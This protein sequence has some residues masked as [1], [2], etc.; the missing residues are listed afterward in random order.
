MAR[1]YADYDNMFRFYTAGTGTS[2]GWPN[3]GGRTLLLRSLLNNA[4]FKERFI[5]RCADLLNSLFR[6]EKVEQTIQ[7][8]ASV[9]RPEI[10][11]HLHRWS[12]SELT[13]RGFGVPH[14]AEY[15]AFTQAT[16][17]T[18]ITVLSA[19]GRNRPAKLRQDCTN[20]FQL[21]GGLGTL[22]VQVQPEGSGRVLLNS[23]T[24]DLFPWQGI[25]FADITNTVRPIPS[26][27][28]RFVEW[29][30]PSGNTNSQ[31][32]SFKVQRDRTNTFTARME[33]APTNPSSPSEL[34][35]TE[36]HYHP[37]ANMDSGDW[38]ELYNPG[39]TSLDLSGWIFRDEEDLHAFPLPNL[40]LPPGGSLVLCED[41]SKFR[42]FHPATVPVAGN[43]QFGLGNSGDTL[44]LFRPDGTVALSIMYDDIAPWPTAADG[45]GSTLQ[46]INLQSDPSLPG[47]WKASSELGGTP[48]R[49]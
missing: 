33:P 10:A 13:Q 25:Y 48:G 38:L 36:I 17:E 34:I 46:L 2:T 26:P 18:N 20:H 23:L 29:I 14:K 9:I 28:Y 40:M 22:Q 39:N 5:R 42:L 49:L 6:E 32:F 4:Q 16:W 8:M 7:E 47:S 12:W 30:T 11:N 35:I 37:P 24:V 31:S 41:D 15:Q 21:T 19:F 44:R 1:D 3:A 27:G 45:G 43:F